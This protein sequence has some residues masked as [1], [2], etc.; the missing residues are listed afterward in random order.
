ML[1]H[2]IT[3]P[4]WPADLAASLSISHL[5]VI[6]FLAPL[7]YLILLTIYNISPLHPLWSY[8]G[9]LLWKASRLTWIISLQRGTLHNDMLALHRK[10]GS[11]V[12][13]A[14]GELSYTDSR[15]FERNATWFK[16]L[17]R[18]EPMSIMGHDERAHALQRRALMGAFSEQAVQGQAEI[19][20]GVVGEWMEKLKERAAG[21]GKENGVDMVEWLEFLLFD[22]SGLLTFGES[23]RSV[24]NGKAHEWVRIS[25]KFGKGV[26]LRAGIN[27]MGGVGVVL[28]GVLGLL[29]PREVKEKVKYHMETSR[30]MAGKKLKGVNREKRADFMDAMIRYNKGVEEKGG[31]GAGKVVGELEMDVTATILIFAGAETTSSALSGVLW[32]LVQESNADVMRKVEE[33][34]R[35]RFEREADIKLG[36]TSDLTYLNAVLSESLRM[37]PPVAIGVPRVVPKGGAIVAGRHV[38]AG[39]Y[40]AVN[41]VPAFTMEENFSDPE[42][43]DPERF[44]ERREADDMA[45][46]NPFGIGRHQ[47]LGMR[48]AWAELRLVLTRLLWTFDIEAVDRTILST[49]SEQQ[50]FIFWQKEPLRLKLTPR[51]T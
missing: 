8:P 16:P 42:K 4:F 38:P 28:G 1:S 26:A 12:R 44:L 5:L 51:R 37:A 2:P 47:C 9:P 32:H 30:E 10:Y 3:P 45:V 6:L 50:T 27:F 46:F 43:F 49:W 41:Q 31:Q 14:P 19:V 21:D 11:V 36:T 15:V 25:S 23:F 7:V 17:R 34:V 18:N 13:I 29:M 35:G 39:T 48:L 24:E 22:I 20:E 33:E 40:V